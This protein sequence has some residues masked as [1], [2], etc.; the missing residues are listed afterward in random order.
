VTLESVNSPPSHSGP[1]LRPVYS[2]RRSIAQTFSKVVR[3]WASKKFIT[4]WYQFS[5]KLNRLEPIQSSRII[6]DPIASARPKVKDPSHLFSHSAQSEA[7]QISDL[8]PKGM[9]WKAH[10]KPIPSNRSDHPNPIHPEEG[11]FLSHSCHSTLPKGPF[12][13]SLRPNSC[14]P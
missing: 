7:H 14:K 12:A 6:P 8:G 5:N 4:G 11:S 13:T 1:I 2:G 9:E 10:L 3:S